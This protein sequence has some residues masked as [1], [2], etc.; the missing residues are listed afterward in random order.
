MPVNRQL[1][2]WLICC[3]AA[4]ALSWAQPAQV[5]PEEGRP[6]PT[7]KELLAHVKQNL[8]GNRLLQ[9]QYTFNRHETTHLID[10]QGEVKKSW[11]KEWEVFP[12]VDPRLSYE[13]LIRKD[14]KPINPSRIQKQDREHRKKLDKAKKL[15]SEQIKKKRLEAQQKEQREIEELFRLFQFQVQGRD[16]VEG[17][18]TFLISFDPRSNYRPELKSVRPLQKMRGQAWVCE[19]DYQLVRVEIELIGAVSVA[20]GAIA[21]LHKGS[22]LQ[23]TRRK[24]NEEIWLPSESNFLLS[25]RIFLVNKFQAEN[26]V[27]YSEYRK[28]A[29]E[30]SVKYVSDSSPSSSE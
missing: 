10:R 14:G 11:S 9:S 3:L 21:R 22:Q 28:F 5:L 19:E 13:R 25:G 6:L 12:S 30:N 1:G 15:S 29:V 16:T 27:V 8:T 24:V 20:L 2:T 7:Q 4:G 18:P 17:V 26:R 23:F